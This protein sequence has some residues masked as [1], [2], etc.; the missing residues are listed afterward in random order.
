MARIRW[1]E[2]SEATGTIGEA[3]AAW[4]AANPGRTQIPASSSA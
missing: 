1:V 2:E 3:Y 4:M